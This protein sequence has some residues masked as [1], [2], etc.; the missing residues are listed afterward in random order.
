M[1]LMWMVLLLQPHF[2]FS[3]T[4]NLCVDCHSDNTLTIER[5]KKTI[6]LFVDNNKFSISVHGMLGC[7]D[8][9]DEFDAENIPHKEGKNIYKVDCAKCHD[10]YV[11]NF[12]NNV[13]Q[14]LV[15]TDKKTPDCVSCHGKHDVKSPSNISSKSKFYCSTC[16][17]NKIL[18][19]SFHNIQS[20]KRSDCA[21]CHK[22][23][24]SIKNKLSK[25][26]HKN[27]ECYDCHSFV[28]TNF[29]DHLKKYPNKEKANCKGCHSEINLIY[30][31]SIHGIAQVEGI[32]ETANC[33]NCHGSHDVLFI[34]DSNNKVHPKNLPKT[35][36]KCHD[37]LKFIKKFEMSFDKPSEHYQNSVHGKLIKN[38]KF[39]G[40]TC[41]SCHGTHDIKN[42]LQ[43]GSKISSYN[44]PSTCEKCHKTIVN[45]YKKSIH[46][47][48]AKKGIRNSPVCTDC[49]NEHSIAEITN[50]NKR[51][52]TKKIQDKTCMDCHTRKNFSDK[53]KTENLE[54]TQYQDSYHGL[55]VERGDK[56]AAMCVDCHGVHKILPKT[57]SASTIHKN[58]VTQ[59]CAKCH[60]EATVNFS[61]SYSHKTENKASKNIEDLITT[62]YIWLILIVIGGMVIHN[63]LIYFYEVKAKRQKEKNHI[64]IPRFTKNEV[65]QHIILF[66]SFIILAFTG[67]ALKYPESWWAIGLFTIGM[68]ETVRQN[69]H[70]I[71]AVAMM[72]L[73]VY[74]IAYLFFTNRGRDVL[75]NFIPKF[76]DL[77]DAIYNIL[78]YLKIKNT[79]PEFGKYDYAEK[80]EYW[81][82]IWGTLIMGI[83]GIVLWFPTN[84]D[85][86]PI[87][88]IKVSEIV[89]FYEAILATLAII[90]WHWFF[91]IFHPKEYPMSLV[92]IDG[93]MSIDDYR[94]HHDLHFKKII[95][96]WVEFKKGKLSETKLSETTLI[97][98]RNL[99][100]SNLS[101]DNI[102]EIEI[103][104][105]KNFKNWFDENIK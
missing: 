1:W 104:K 67:F 60:K 83:T 8:C 99:N 32:T 105:D 45:D 65:I 101:L 33:W 102:I 23:Y 71:S 100:K 11:E 77:K 12:K 80:A 75:K 41:T 50:E 35:C 25:T 10:D 14:K 82:L 49:H 26:P 51:S 103:K 98:E 27:F 61:Q 6:S 96:E 74:H 88:L 64:S 48:R 66:T 93:K 73:G 63:L 72:T 3:Q 13:H 90:V 86:A 97:F 24:K 34:K 20:V 68:T 7:V 76:S 21:T 95:K 52:E 4:E 36:G 55:A 47:T 89:H 15:S 91:V 59:T 5:N 62:I 29:N 22:E 57:N 92:W 30:N 69:I 39:E 70:R 19:K 17:E 84:F 79:K 87:W 94:L 44:V 37:D 42:R 31:E 16:H 53:F 40:A 46:W 9:H 56:D 78:F 18:T 28:A 58:N 2:I 43:E 54:A 85:W 81:A 38:G